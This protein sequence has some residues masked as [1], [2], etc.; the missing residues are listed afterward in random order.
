[1]RARREEFQAIVAAIPSRYRRQRPGALWAA[2]AALWF[3]AALIGGWVWDDLGRLA[4]LVAGAPIVIALI[5]KDIRQKRTVIAGV[6]EEAPGMDEEE[7][8]SLV[9]A[10]ES[11]YGK[12]EMESLRELLPKAA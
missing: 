11:Y 8:R 12:A 10:L 2:L 5:R 3:A 9:E 6:S 1:M 4:A 7:L